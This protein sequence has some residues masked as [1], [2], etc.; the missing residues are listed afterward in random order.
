MATIKPLCVVEGCGKR[1]KR[2]EAVFCSNTCRGKHLHEAAAKVLVP[3]RRCSA[4]VERLESRVR[5]DKKHGSVRVHCENCYGN[6]KAG[7]GYITP[8]G[9][10]RISVRS[11]GPS[12]IERRRAGIRSTHRLVLEHR[13]IWEQAHGPIPEG[14]TIHHRNGNR[15][16]NRLCNLELWVGNHGHGAKILDLAADACRDPLFR[17]NLMLRLTL[18]EEKSA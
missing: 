6:R 3:C 9:Y 4:P 15:L 10:K 16:D 1:V 13:L 7:T 2:S 17:S 11:D 18:Q 14:C 5:N 12:Y 8:D